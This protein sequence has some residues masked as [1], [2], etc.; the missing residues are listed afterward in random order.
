MVSVSCHF[1]CVPGESGPSKTQN[2]KSQGCEY[3]FPSWVP[4]NTGEWG[5]P[6]PPP[7]PDPCFPG[8]GNPAPCHTSSLR[9]SSLYFLVSEILFWLS[10]PQNQPT[11]LF[12]VAPG[13]PSSFPQHCP[14]HTMWVTCCSTEAC[15]LG[16]F[17]SSLLS[18]ATRGV[19]Q[20]GHVGVA[21]TCSGSLLVSGFAGS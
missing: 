8:I 21:V 2:L 18:R 20:G 15:P 9:A 1:C 4:V 17:P 7:G 14:F 19:S 6:S 13:S 12:P 11:Q 5:S 3:R 16:T 10:R